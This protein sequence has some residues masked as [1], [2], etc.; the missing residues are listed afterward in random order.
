M[1]QSERL[2][3]EDSC[4]TLVQKLTEKLVEKPN[5]KIQEQDLQD[6][7]VS[8]SLASEGSVL[9][10]QVRYPF[11]SA[12][13]RHG[14]QNLLERV[15]AG[16]PLKLKVEAQ[17]GI[18]NIAVNVQ[19]L[20][21]DI[22]ARQS[23]AHLLA[24][25]R[26]WLFIGP[27]VER[28]RWLRDEAKRSAGSTVPSAPPALLGLQVRQLE[29]CWIVLKSDRVVVI[30][31]VHL[32]DEADTALARAFCQEFAETNRRDSSLPCLFSEPKDVPSDLRALSL[33]AVPN[34]G[35]LTLTLSDQAVLGMS[36]ERLYALARPVMFFRNFFMFHLKHA[37]G[38]LHSRL[39]RRLDGWQQQLARARRVKSQGQEKRRL[40]SGKEFVPRGASASGGYPGTE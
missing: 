27:L 12:V 21:E 16:L 30:I 20:G 35:F 1:S 13:L 11:L 6:F 2:F 5:D 38:Y 29:V 26:S 25:V 39:R 23:C 15:W 36:D 9:H 10:F 24:S 28:L 19:D 7:E 3:L 33:E 4:P 14:S 37:K 34:V 18:L 17:H 22:A 31:G 40:A 8:Y 32:E